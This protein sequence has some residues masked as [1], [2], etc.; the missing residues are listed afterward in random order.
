MRL[1]EQ[2][3][4][5]GK[6]DLKFD[7]TNEP[8]FAFTITRKSNGDVL[9]DTRGSVLVYE[10]QFIEFVSK[11]PEN[12][13]LYGL[14]EN[15]HNLRLGN[16]YTITMYAADD[17]NPI[18]RNIYGT[19]PVAIDTR[20]YEVNGKQQTLVTTQNTSATGRYVAKS[21]GFYNRNAHA[22]E[23]LLREESITW[24]TIGGSIDLYFLDGPSAQDVISQ[25]QSG[26]IE[27]P[28]LQQYWTFGFHQCRW[29]YKNWSQVEEVV[30]TYR[31][32]NIPL[33]TIWNDIGTLSLSALKLALTMTRLYVSVS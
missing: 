15:I 4:P 20:Y 3:K 6:I 9:F 32:F 25:Y 16:N 21:H 23:I 28:A 18:D 31:Q 10:N 24:R 27:L 33:E 17:G 14:G 5:S 1:P 29:G 26:V 7:W 19:H 13:N 11:L 2:G 8:S 22:H 30:D 12:Y